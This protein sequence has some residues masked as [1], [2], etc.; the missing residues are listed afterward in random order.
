MPGPN[1][2]LLLFQARAILRKQLPAQPPDA[3][4][5]FPYSHHCLEGYLFG[6]H[7]SPIEI[8]NH[9]WGWELE[10]FLPDACYDDARHADLILALF[11]DMEEAISQ[12]QLFRIHSFHI[13]ESIPRS[14]FDKHPLWHWITGFLDGFSVVLSQLDGLPKKLRKTN[15]FRDLREEYELSM[16]ICMS[17]FPFKRPAGDEE[18]PGEEM[19]E[20]SET[21]LPE[22][23]SR[24]MEGICATAIRATHRIDKIL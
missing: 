4:G 22:L 10:R 2:S 5:L 14:E 9:V 16:A 20:L 6:I 13:P 3:D 12:D 24:M 19:A 7:A 23:F 17:V 18:C 11:D 1:R 15:E 21:P 8:E